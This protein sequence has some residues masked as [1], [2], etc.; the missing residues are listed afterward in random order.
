MASSVIS[1]SAEGD[2][3]F[4]AP[5]ITPIVSRTNRDGRRCR[6]TVGTSGTAS[7]R[8]PPAVNTSLPLSPPE[9]PPPP[10]TP[11]VVVD[12]PHFR[13]ALPDAKVAILIREILFIQI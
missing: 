3:H 5:R 7:S 1:G 6:Y 13:R 10:S 4:R 11:R 12:G 9:L 8:F 2:Y